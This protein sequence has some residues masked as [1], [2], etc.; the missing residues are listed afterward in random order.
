[1]DT[2][3][4]AAAVRLFNPERA[5][6]WV[7]GQSPPLVLFT[8]SPDPEAPI[9]ALLATGIE[10][11][12]PVT[13]YLDLY[14]LS[15][16]SSCAKTSPLG[17]F[18]NGLELIDVYWVPGVGPAP[19]QEGVVLTTWRV[20]TELD[21]PP[22]PIVANPPPPG[23][24]NGPR[25]AAFAHVLTDGGT[26]LAGDDGLWVDPLTLRPGDRFVQA[27]RFDLPSDAPP[28]P[29]ALTLGLYDPLTGNR[30]A[31]LDPHEGASSDSVLVT[32]G[33]GEP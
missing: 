26:R 8:S 15:D 11:K 6:V 25:L 33:G 5:L 13:R 29:Y 24:Y 2:W 30:W 28:G 9:D 14:A 32:P 12:E 21:L 1:V 20:A 23:V 7:E 3:P 31:V 19:G 18:A 27:H 4:D 10:R 17:R 16:T 22:L